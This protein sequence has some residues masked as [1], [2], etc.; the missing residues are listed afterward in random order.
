ME[1]VNNNKVVID[2]VEYDINDTSN[3]VEDYIEGGYILRKKN[4]YI[5]A[6]E[7]PDKIENGWLR[8]KIVHTQSRSKLTNYSV[9][10]SDR[11]P[12]AISNLVFRTE[13]E[14]DEFCEKWGYFRTENLKGRLYLNKFKK[15]DRIKPVEFNQIKRVRHVEEYYKLPFMP[16]SKKITKEYSELES[17]VKALNVKNGTD[18]YTYLA[19]EG[20]DFS[21]GLELE[22]VS[23]CIYTSELSKGNHEDLN[24]AGVFDGSLRDE[25]GSGPWGQEYITGVLKGDA[26]LIQANKIVNLL[27]KYCTVDSRTAFHVH[28]GSLK[29]NSEDIVF[30]YILGLMIEN[31][32]MSIMP[33]SRRNNQYC[34]NLIGMPKSS[35]NLL[36]NSKSKEE[37]KIAITSLYNRI[38]NIVGREGAPNKYSNKRTRHPKGR[39]G[40]YDRNSDHRYSW[41]NFTNIIFNQ[42]DDMSEKT[43]EYRCH[44]GTLSFVKIYNWVKICMAI[45]A[46]VRLGKKDILKAIKSNKA[47]T[48][49]C[50]LKRVYKRSS[51]SLINYIELRKDLFSTDSNE[52]EDYRKTGNLKIKNAKD[53][54][55]V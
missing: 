17:E 5:Y 8:T 4:N 53:L 26:G 33:I 19:F 40:G 16:V 31:E 7:V 30:A 18:S 50:I 27:S 11:D 22:T 41:L 52:N 20:I 29:W 35:I 37:Y 38:F 36:K 21:Y 49:E 24:F 3:I 2:G 48:L 39:H 23:G 45:T 34:K 10:L 1:E 55:C 6:I 32:I 14:V 9:Q 12:E 51:S 15:L 13:K 54:L 47:I 28:I 46:F 43:I 42:R 25:D 44:P